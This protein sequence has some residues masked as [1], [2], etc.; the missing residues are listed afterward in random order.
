M[1]IFFVYLSSYSLLFCIYFLL[2]TR[3]KYLA[4]DL[5][6]KLHTSFMIAVMRA[7]TNFIF[8]LILTFPKLGFS[9]VILVAIFLRSLICKHP[10]LDNFSIAEILSIRFSLVSY[11]G[12][13]AFSLGT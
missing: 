6:K 11:L 4:I 10:R 2:H 8:L 1:Q 12:K 9:Y 5:G 3:E 13:G 7:E